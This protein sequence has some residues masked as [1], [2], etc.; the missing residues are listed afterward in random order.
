MENSETYEEPA[1]AGIETNQTENQTE[2]AET[3]TYNTDEIYGV[4]TETGVMPAQDQTTANPAQSETTT[5]TPLVTETETA[6]RG[7]TAE[8]FNNYQTE[9]R[10]GTIFIIFMLAMIFGALIGWG[11]SKIWKM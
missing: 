11:F 3:L 6:Y 1:Q 9:T 7:V 4:Q 8:Q 10:T 5:V 2:T